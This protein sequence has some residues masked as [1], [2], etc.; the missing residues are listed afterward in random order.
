MVT[1]D[2]HSWQKGPGS[3]ASSEDNV[4]MIKPMFQRCRSILGHLGYWHLIWLLPL[5]ACCALVALSFI[6][7]RSQEDL[8][9]SIEGLDGDFAVVGEIDSGVFAKLKQSLEA[10][11]NGMINL[12]GKQHTYIWLRNS[13]FD[14][15]WLKQHADQLRKQPRLEMALWNCE[16]T[17]EGLMQVGPI[18]QLAGLSLHSAKISGRSLA[19]PVCQS[20]E[21]LT[22]P[23]ERQF[24]AEIPE[25]CILPELRIVTVKIS[26]DSPN[27]EWLIRQPKLEY[28]AVGGKG[29]SAD[30]VSQLN[31]CNRIRIINID[32]ADN[33]T[34]SALTQL[35]IQVE[36]RIPASKLTEKCLPD[37]DS[38]KA[39][40]KLVLNEP[41]FSEEILLKLSESGV[42]VNR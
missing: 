26:D 28:V 2:G 9:Y 10:I 29:L 42:V 24:A 5:L 7:S 40:H 20:L 22:I 17:D 19:A 1:N 21:K 25:N 31:R 6:S 27:L 11:S 4:T 39:K 37:L 30:T 15:S 8:G 41:P 16:I 36:L 33:E 34:I 18:P 3:P 38:L 13:G 35:A 23:G 14:D 12:P 32:G